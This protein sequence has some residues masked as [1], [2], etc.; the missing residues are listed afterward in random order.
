MYSDQEME[1]PMCDEHQRSPVCPFILPSV[2]PSHNS[3]FIR[4]TEGIRAME[5]V[6]SLQILNELQSLESALQMRQDINRRQQSF[7]VRV[8]ECHLCLATKF[9][10]KLKNL[11]IISFYV[12]YLHYLK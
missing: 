6:A 9:F 2:A 3:R 7:M 11:L 8:N 12:S 5:Q 4:Y 1:A 10:K